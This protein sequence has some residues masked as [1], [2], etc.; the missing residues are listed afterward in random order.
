MPR[1]DLDKHALT[2]SR[3]NSIMLT[4]ELEQH[5]TRVFVQH[6]S[7]EFAVDSQG[8]ADAVFCQRQCPTQSKFTDR[9]RVLDSPFVVHQ[10]AANKLVQTDWTRLGK[11]GLVGR[12]GGHVQHPNGKHHSRGRQRFWIS[13]LV[14]IEHTQWTEA[15]V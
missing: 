1:F 9:E 15:Q 11:V 8:A 4:A 12:G 7:V 14:L 3:R 10:H 6:V 13:R 5:T 2:T